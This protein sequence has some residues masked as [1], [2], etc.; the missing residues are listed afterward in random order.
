MGGTLGGSKVNRENGPIRDNVNGGTGG[1]GSGG[2]VALDVVVV[3]YRRNEGFGCIRIAGVYESS[4]EN[5]VW[6]MV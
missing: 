5:G 3:E 1:S 4:R 6:T 2:V